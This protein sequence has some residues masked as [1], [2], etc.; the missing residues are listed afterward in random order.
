MILDTNALSAWFDGDEA[1][2]D[3]MGPAL[4]TLPVIVVGEYHYG[5]MGS[6]QRQEREDWLDRVVAA[7]QVLPVTLATADAYAL[8]RRELHSKGRP[9]PHNDLWI[10]ALALQ[11]DL[12][13]LSR[14]KHFDVVDGVRRLSW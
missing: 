13:I 10:A 3:A 9:I 7:V 4:L 6:S 2:L 8:L 5:V 1:L 11:H 14:D 12:P